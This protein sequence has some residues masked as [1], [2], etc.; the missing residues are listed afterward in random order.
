[1]VENRQPSFF[2]GYV[3]VLA[4]FSIMVVVWG[5]YYSF[6]VILKPMSAEFGWT[7]AATSSALSL[8]T[9]VFGIFTI[10]SG[11]L[12]DRFGPR[13]V[14]SVCGLLLGAGYLLLS[15][16]STLWHLYLFYGL[17]IGVGMGG[18]FFPLLTTVARWF[19]KRRGLMTGIAAAGIG[20]GILIVPVAASWLI[21]GY[22]WRFAF[23]AMGL[24]ALVLI[25]LAAQL[26]KRDPDQMGQLAYGTGE[27]GPGS[28]NMQA[29]GFSLREAVHTR[30]FWITWGIFFCGGFVIFTVMVHMAPHATDLGLPAT[31]AAGILSVIGLL[32]IAGRV[33]I[34]SIGDRVGHRSALIISFVPMAMVLFWVMGASEVWM[35]YLFA[36]IFGFTYGGFSALEQ[37]VI[38]DL[39]GLRSL[40]LLSGFIGW[41]FTVGGAVGPWL[42]GRIF[43]IFG[44]YQLAFLASGVASAI[45]F[46]LVLFLK[47]LK[48][49]R[50]V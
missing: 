7:R 16:I 27:L 24:A 21:S 30:Q 26:L 33:V 9:F 43:D 4:V 45:G 15:Q 36:I 28:L 25:I 23:M 2:Y 29:S 32:S 5:T 46:L 8:G 11:R 22:G 14:L 48:Q 50:G 6:G 13:I 38:A 3:I 12:T 19:I 44:S 17:V 42:G 31:T 34:G 35:L 40:G 49:Q 37:P 10:V 39:F 47:P 1:M 41:G 18:G 20:A